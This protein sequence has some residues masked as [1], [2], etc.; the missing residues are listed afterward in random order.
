[1]AKISAIKHKSG[2]IK[3][4]VHKFLADF[5]K[6]GRNVA[7]LFLLRVLH[8]KALIIFKNKMVNPWM[9]STFFILT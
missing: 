2:P 6:N 3:I 7:K 8:I 9:N 1:M 4:S 5:S